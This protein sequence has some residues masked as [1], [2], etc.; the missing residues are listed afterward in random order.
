MELKR[1]LEMI[2]ILQ[3]KVTCKNL[4]FMIKMTRF[5]NKALHFVDR[6]VLFDRVT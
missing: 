2:A 6:Y 3:M 1:T 4:S 5:R